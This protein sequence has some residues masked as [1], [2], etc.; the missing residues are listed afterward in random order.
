M[1]ALLDLQKHV[2]DAVVL[3]GGTG[4]DS[5]LLGG[6][7]PSRRLAIHQRHY[8]VSL[9]RALLERFPATVWLVGSSFVTMSA[10]TFLGAAMIA[11]LTV[12]GCGR[13]SQPSSKSSESPSTASSSDAVANVSA[14]APKRLTLTYDK[15]RMPKPVVGTPVEVTADGLPPNKDVSLAWGTVDGGWVIEDYFHFRGKKYT[16]TTRTL[17]QATTDGSGRL[18]ARFTIPED[19]GGVHDAIES[20]LAAAVPRKAVLDAHVRRQQARGNN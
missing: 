6:R 13:G 2:R 5:L 17:S 7:D 19:F 4:L 1:P 11:A 18:N 8:R 20:P 15:T 16:E 9:T 12:P 10:A 14:P 3:N